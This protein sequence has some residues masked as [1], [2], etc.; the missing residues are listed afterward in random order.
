MV[1][2]LRTPQVEAA[3][4]GGQAELVYARNEERLNAIGAESLQV[5]PSLL[6]CKTSISNLC[7]VM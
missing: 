7:F 5:G 4:Y 1:V 6:V 2:L 3:R